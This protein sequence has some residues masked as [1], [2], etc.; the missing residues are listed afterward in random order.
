MIPALYNHLAIEIGITNSTVF[1]SCGNIFRVI[2]AKAAE[3]MDTM[4]NL[5]SKSQHISTAKLYLWD[6]QFEVDS[7]E[8]HAV[9]KYLVKNISSKARDSHT[10]VSSEVSQFASGMFLFEAKVKTV[11]KFC[12]YAK[13]LIISVSPWC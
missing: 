3:K 5:Y 6:T 7:G 9:E 8:A 2:Y 1:R 12:C 13:C 11:M 10:I 4:I